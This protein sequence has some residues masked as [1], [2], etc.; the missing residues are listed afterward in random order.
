MSSEEGLQPINPAK[1]QTLLKMVVIG[2]SGA[3][4]REVVRNAAIDPAVGTIKIITRRILP[5]WESDPVISRK[6][7]IIKLDHYDNLIS[8][9]S[10]ISDS[11]FDVFFCCLGTTQKTGK[12]N[13]KKVDYTYCLRSAELAKESNIPH[14]SVVSSA[15]TDAT[16]SFFYLK[17]KGEMERDIK[18][19][20]FGYC[21]VAKPGFLRNRENDS[22][23]GEKFWWCFVCCAANIEIKTLGAAL[24]IDAIRYWQ[25]RREGG[26]SGE[27]ERGNVDLSN[28]QLKDI[29]KNYEG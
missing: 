22:R 28:E 2:A 13:F 25:V 15:G 5:E 26:G 4:G 11:N 1:V 9:K 6:I 8:L 16:S 14:F 24:V 17:T 21:T 27:L 7:T 10:E 19:I 23:L 18:K 3:S 20:G 12:E 29:V